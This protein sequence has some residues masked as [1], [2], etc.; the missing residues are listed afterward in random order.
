MV[1]RPHGVRAVCEQPP[2]SHS[3]VHQ[4][5]RLGPWP[6]QLGSTGPGGGPTDEAPIMVEEARRTNGEK[7]IEHAEPLGS[8]GLNGAGDG[9]VDFIPTGGEDL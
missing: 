9:P 6:G 3:C 1:V 4:G 2:S 5:S 8:L 7:L